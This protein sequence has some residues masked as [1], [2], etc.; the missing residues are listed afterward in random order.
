MKLNRQFKIFG[1]LTI[2]TA[3]H[4][5]LSFGIFAYVFKA[6]FWVGAYGGVPL[7]DKV[8]F[9]LW[10]PIMTME[11]LLPVNFL[12]RPYGILIVIGNSIVW[13]NSIVLIVYLVKRRRTRKLVPG[14]SKEQAP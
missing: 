5:A 13:V 4:F 2:L 6:S 14:A 7:V 11:P 12:T 9:V 10:W 1:L 8:L 3:L